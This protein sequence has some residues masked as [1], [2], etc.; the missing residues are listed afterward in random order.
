MSGQ[1]SALTIL[2]ILTALSTS[3]TLPSQTQVRPVN[4]YFVL[5]PTTGHGFIATA[6]TVAACAMPTYPARSQPTPCGGAGSPCGVAPANSPSRT[7][8]TP[9]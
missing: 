7:C 3:W 1:R 4:H 8:G 2:A 5:D 9:A 6:E